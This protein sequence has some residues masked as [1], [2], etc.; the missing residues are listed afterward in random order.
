M[1]GMT[2]MKQQA[3][4]TTRMIIIL[5]SL[6][7]LFFLIPISTQA[8]GEIHVNVNTLNVRFGPGLD[9]TVIDKISKDQTYKVIEE[10]DAWFHIALNETTTGW[11]ANW[12]VEFTA[13][14]QEKWVESTV[15]RLNVR[16]GPSTS[17]N[18]VGQIEPGQRYALIKE[19][20]DWMLI[21]LDYQNQGWV[22]NWLVTIHEEAP[23]QAPDS[24]VAEKKRVEILA[25][26]LNVRET[27]SVDSGIVDKLPQ[28]SVVEV[29]NQNGDWYEVEANGAVI[30]WIANWLV[31]E[32]QAE[33]VLGQVTILNQGTNLRSGP[34]TSNNVLQRA[35]RGDTFD[36]L[37]VKG[38][39]YQIRLAN[40]ETAYVAGW[41]VSVS[42]LAPIVRSQELRGKTI[43]VDPGH[44][45]RDS[46]ATGAHFKTL[47]KVVNLQVSN[48]LKDKLE[49]A[50]ARVVMTRTDD[51][52][53]SLQQRVDISIQQKADA[54][55]SIHH[56]T[57]ND[58]RI[59]GTITYF[60]SSADRTLATEIQAELVKQNG[61][62]DLRAR[63][64]N[65]FVLRENPRPSVL[66]ELGFLSNYNDELTIRTSRFQENSA[67]G[68]T[69][70]VIN[71]FKK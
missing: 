64:G 57:N 22:A 32:V 17:H 51:R 50:G 43:V 46:G 26:V 20:S 59:N 13:Q 24:G 63:S 60:H 3:K 5:T 27:S 52:F 65:F 49:V 37:A 42:G 29:V 19:E 35:N 9:Y 53:I 31:R 14:T 61:L 10:K 62:N 2:V 28:G 39:W 41:I 56:N 36:V 71:Y 21:Q 4:T 25:S 66:I 40:G 44:G 30:G 7:I 70:G 67:I 33:G 23:T 34:A 6:V 54:F 1:R 8:M 12:L 18:L 69:Q 38:D 48:L 58:S 55:L 68:I 45:G 15:T 11:V 16:S 47:E